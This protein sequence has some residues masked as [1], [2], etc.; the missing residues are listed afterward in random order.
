MT[1]HRYDCSTQTVKAYANPFDSSSNPA[2]E[3]SVGAAYVGAVYD[4][5]N[6]QIVFVPSDQALRTTWH[7]FQNYGKPQVSRQFAAHY[8]FNKF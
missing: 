4:P 3:Q 7:V 2:D 8:L 5:L 6:N 1:W